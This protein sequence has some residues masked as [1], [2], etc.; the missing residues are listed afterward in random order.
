MRCICCY[1]YAL[2]HNLGIYKAVHLHSLIKHEFGE[3]TQY[4]EVARVGK[5]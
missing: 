1:L 2:P 5:H 3:V 4:K